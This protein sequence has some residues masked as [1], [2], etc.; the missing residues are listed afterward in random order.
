MNFFEARRTVREYGFEY[1]EE[2]EA[3][4][5]GKFRNRDP[6][7]DNIPADPD[8]IYRFVGWRDWKDWLVDPEKRV[9]YTD[10][11]KAR[12]FVRSCR[13]PGRESWLEFLE[14]NADLIDGYSMKLPLRPHLEYCDAGWKSWEDWLGSEISYNDFKS[15][16]KFIHSLKLKDKKEWNEFC[17]GRLLHKPE[18]SERI[19]AYP[20]LAYRDEGWKSWENWLGTGGAEEAGPTPGVYEVIIDCKCKGRIKDCPRCGGKGYYEVR[21]S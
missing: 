17:S 14:Q 9:L 18:R 19:F 4:V 1:R 20:E 2:W 12:D 13:L 8:R 6:L 3:F 7:P 21:M 5:A 11:N 15:T 10:F 16:R